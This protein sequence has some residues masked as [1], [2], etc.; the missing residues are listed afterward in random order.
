MDLKKN[1]NIK[2]T[3]YAQKWLENKK[4]TVEQFM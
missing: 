2:F 3:D 4:G 1:W